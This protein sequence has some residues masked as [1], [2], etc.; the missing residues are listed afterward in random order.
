MTDTLITIL[1]VAICFLPVYVIFSFVPYLTR[2]AGSFGIGILE[3]NIMIG[4]WSLLK[5]GEG[6]NRICDRKNLH[7]FPYIRNML[8][9]ESN[10]TEEVC[11][12][13]PCSED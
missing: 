2:K 8:E 5:K 9:M 1:Y 4:W 12:A 13:L 6:G 10:F 11:F 3:K 7:S